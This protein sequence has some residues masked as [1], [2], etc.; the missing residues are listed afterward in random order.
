LTLETNS[1]EVQ[2]K[3]WKACPLNRFWA[4][5]CWLAEEESAQDQILPYDPEAAQGWQLVDQS[6]TS[7]PPINKSINQETHKYRNPEI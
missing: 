3:T 5:C 2:P 1:P 7:N 6:K 4:W